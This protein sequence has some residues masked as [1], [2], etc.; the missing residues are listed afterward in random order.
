MAA[1][2][3]MMFGGRSAANRAERRLLVPTSPTPLVPPR[4]SLLSVETR[5]GSTGFGRS[6]MT[7]M[8]VL[9]MTKQEGGKRG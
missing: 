9:A 8:A 4:V 7:G 5:A 1:L 2:L 6:V 3:P